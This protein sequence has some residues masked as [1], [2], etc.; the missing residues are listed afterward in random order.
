MD[1]FYGFRF[2]R[3][4]SLR[5]VFGRPREFFFLIETDRPIKSLADSS[6][7]SVGFYLF[8]FYDNDVLIGRTIHFRTLLD[9]E[10]FKEVVAIVVE[11]G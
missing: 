3:L 2:D 8:F 1:G 7:H 11:V 9:E 5:A 10:I 4:R 6:L